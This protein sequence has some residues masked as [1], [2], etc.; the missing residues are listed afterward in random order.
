LVLKPLD[1]P[2]PQYNW[3]KMKLHPHQPSAKKKSIAVSSHGLAANS[4]WGQQTCAFAAP[5]ALMK[6]HILAK[7]AKPNQETMAIPVNSYACCF[8]RNYG[9]HPYTCCFNSS[10]PKSLK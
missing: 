6:D 5:D 3:L 4:I 10:Q 8:K 1:F 2:D 9:N 7:L